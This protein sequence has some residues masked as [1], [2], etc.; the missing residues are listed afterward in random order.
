MIHPFKLTLF[1]KKT[2]ILNI[3]IQKT[4]KIKK[5]SLNL[6]FRMNQRCPKFFPITGI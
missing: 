4:T 2:Y 5:V 1:K 6:T 3:K